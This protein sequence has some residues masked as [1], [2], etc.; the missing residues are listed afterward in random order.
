MHTGMFKCVSNKK[1]K[2]TRLCSITFI[3]GCDGESVLLGKKSNPNFSFSSL[4]LL[5]SD[6]L[7]EF[8]DPQA[9]KPS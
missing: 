1:Q 2:Q 3:C 9:S 6:V 8:L 5:L 7:N 4:E